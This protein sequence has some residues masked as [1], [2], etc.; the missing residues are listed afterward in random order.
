MRL[1]RATNGTA[2]DAYYRI[3]TDFEKVLSNYHAD[4]L[5][6]RTEE[7]RTQRRHHMDKAVSL[8]RERYLAC[9]CTEG[10]GSQKQ[11][12]RYI[13]VP[14]QCLLDEQCSSVQVHLKATAQIHRGSIAMLV[15]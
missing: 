8:L 2:D 1:P 3:V 12:H 7:N 10:C 6:L 14:L 11:Q 13:E 15:G 9:D 4:F 5:Q